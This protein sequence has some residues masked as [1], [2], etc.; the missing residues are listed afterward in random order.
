MRQRNKQRK[1]SLA[2]N[3]ILHYTICFNREVANAEKDD[4]IPYS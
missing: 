2:T 4:I 1:I 3:I